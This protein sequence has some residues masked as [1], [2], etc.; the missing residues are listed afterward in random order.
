MLY[1]ITERTLPEVGY[2]SVLFTQN[3][4]SCKRYMMGMYGAV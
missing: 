1:K 3:F 2:F 4:T